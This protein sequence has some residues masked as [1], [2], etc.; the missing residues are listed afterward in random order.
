M[1]LARIHGLYSCG[2]GKGCSQAGGGG[3]VDLCGGLGRTAA[4]RV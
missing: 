2:H 1:P 3:Y 4:F